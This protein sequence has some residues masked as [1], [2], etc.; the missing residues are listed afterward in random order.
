MAALAK[1]TLVGNLTRDPETKTTPSG[2]RCVTFTVAV[3]RKVKGEDRASFLDV[4]CWGKQGDYVA[5]YLHKGDPVLVEGDL[6]Q[7]RWEAKDGTKR[8][9]VVIKGWTV[10][11]LGSRQSGQGGRQRQDSGFRDAQGEIPLNPHSKPQRRHVDL[12]EDDQVPF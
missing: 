10:Q 5:Q 2:A 9:R 8:S 4:E 3:N 1:A 12:P 7:Q 6:E 11:G